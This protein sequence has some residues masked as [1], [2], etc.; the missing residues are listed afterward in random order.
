MFGSKGVGE[1]QIL[2]EFQGS[3]RELV[4]DEKK[5]RVTD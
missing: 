1:G 2:T 4:P 3:E 5:I